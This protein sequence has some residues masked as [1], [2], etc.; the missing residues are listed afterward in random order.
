M[1]LARGEDDGGGAL[2]GAETR[3][4]TMRG[5][6]TQEEGSGVVG[7][8]VAGEEPSQLAIGMDLV[9]DERNKAEKTMEASGTAGSD[10]CS[11]RD[12]QIRCRR[13]GRS[14][15]G[16]WS[17]LTAHRSST[18]RRRLPGLAAH[19]SIS[20]TRSVLGWPSDHNR[21]Q[22]HQ[23]RYR[24][25]RIVAARRGG[26]AREEEGSGVVGSGVAGEEPAAADAKQAA[27]GSKEER[28]DHGELA[29][30]WCSD[31]SLS[32]SLQKR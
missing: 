17:S 19:R 2:M 20:N 23:P 22:A 1:Q 29:T 12:D 8:G 27:R 15:E 24:P 10:R 30:T 14:N 11:V 21:L 3:P 28:G 18:G 4:V 26:R 5:C 13:R 31:L 7:P 25:L 6:G 16:G 9:W 32:L